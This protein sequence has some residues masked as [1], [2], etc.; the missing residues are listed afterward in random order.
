MKPTALVG[1]A[2]TAD[3]DGDIPALLFFIVPPATLTVRTR[4]SNRATAHAKIDA[5]ALIGGG[6]G[7]DGDAEITS[8][9]DNTAMIGPD[10]NVNVSGAVTVDAG[11]N[12]ANTADATID[13]TS[14]G[15]VSGAVIASE[16]HINGA[17]LAELD[18]SVDAGGSLTVQA[19]GTNNSTATTNSFGLGGI[20]FSGAGSLATIDSQADVTAK[21]GSSASVQNDV[22]VTATSTNTAKATSD[23]ATGGLLG[24][25]SVNQPTA[26]VDGA[27]LAEFDGDVTNGTSVGISATSNN[28]AT[29][30]ASVISIGGLI[31]NAGASSDAEIGSDA[32]TNAIVGSTS[33]I[34]APGVDILVTATSSNTAIAKA[35]GGGGGFGV[36]VVVMKPTA[37]DG[38]G[39]NAGFNGDITSANS[40]TVRSRT[41]D[42]ANAHTNVV[43]ISLVAGLS[44]G[45]ASAAITAA[46][47]GKA[48][49]GSTAH[50]TVDG[51]VLVDAGQSA[52]S[53]ATANADGGGGGLVSGAA[54]F[55]GAS[56]GGVTQAELDGH[57]LDSSSVTVQ[58]NGSNDAEGHTH[59]VGIGLGFAV[60]GAGVE[61]TVA[62]SAGVNA[63]VG[64]GS[65]STRYS[66]TSPRRR[67]TPRTRPPTPQTAASASPAA[68]IS[69]PRW[70]AAGRRPPWARP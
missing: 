57:V 53:T 64:G 70:W 59:S 31:A 25:I 35:D 29:A 10:A 20:S 47:V 42:S 1:G 45:F 27:T 11:Q 41:A 50:I 14:F 13:A 2:T 55:A 21:T 26:K 46:A 61:A 54:F 39:T 68:S 56:V 66:S 58:A 12:S 62:S 63:I 6:A 3:F 34:D 30:E 16:A 24:A 43:S 33:S 23:A 19:N 18:G 51:A 67:T 52:T 9:A 65:I 32:T 60:S 4:T 7:G 8:T 22:S 40:L 49:I 38:G 48:S 36:S 28:T 37:I 15:T 69:R 17:V 5:I 44:G